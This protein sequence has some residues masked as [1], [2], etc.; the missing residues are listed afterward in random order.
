MTRIHRARRA[1]GAASMLLLFSTACSSAGGLGGILGNVLGGGGGEVAGSIQGINT[2]SQQIDL[3]QTN[4]QRVVLTYDN[5]TQVV[6]QGQNYPVTSLEFGDEVRARIA[7]GGNSSSYTD[8]IDVTRSVSDGGT[9]G[10][11]NVRAF[12]GNVRNI[13]RTNGVFTVS[14]NDYGTI[15]VT[16]PYNTRQTDLTRFQNLRTGDYARFYGVLL[17]NSRVELRQFY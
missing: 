7:S 16:M 8:R 2:R 14:S 10:T 9:T 12:E 15:T 3:R 4:G 11:G 1:A 13:D 5:N 17:N 6:F